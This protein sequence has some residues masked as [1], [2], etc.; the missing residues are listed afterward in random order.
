[1]KKNSMMIKS[2]KTIHHNSSYQIAKKAANPNKENKEPVDGGEKTQVKKLWVKKKKFQ[3][4]AM[5]NKN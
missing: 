3:L 4:L 1:M 5:Y 2:K